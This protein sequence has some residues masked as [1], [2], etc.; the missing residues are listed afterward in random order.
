M[1]KIAC[2]GLG[3][4]LT[5][6]L[7]GAPAVRAAEAKNVAKKVYQ[8]YCAACHGSDGKGDGVVSGFMRPKARI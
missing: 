6:M 3:A 8:Q 4:A 7:A 2:L 5:A 1:R